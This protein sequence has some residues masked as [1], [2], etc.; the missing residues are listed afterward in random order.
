MAQRRLRFKARSGGI[1]LSVEQFR[2]IP[3]G[4]H[5]DG[6]NA[7][8]MALRL[9]IQLWNGKTVNKAVRV[10]IAFCRDSH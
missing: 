10:R 5:D 3:V 7:L 8:E 4:E 6:P 2:D 1:A 9:M